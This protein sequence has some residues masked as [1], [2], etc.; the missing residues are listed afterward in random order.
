MISR[1][2]L[3]EQ[4]WRIFTRDQFNLYPWIKYSYLQFFSGYKY[5]LISCCEKI[6][7][8]MNFSL[9]KFSQIVQTDLSVIKTKTKIRT[10]SYYLNVESPVSC[11]SVVSHLATGPRHCIVSY[12]NSHMIL[13]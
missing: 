7:C 12:V 8:E 1:V 9:E 4:P 2:R 5:G 13:K 11:S 3:F 6:T 10:S